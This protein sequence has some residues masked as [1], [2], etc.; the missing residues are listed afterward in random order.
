MSWYV[1]NFYSWQAHTRYG[2]QLD[3]LSGPWLLR[4]SQLCHAVL[5]PKDDPAYGHTAHPDFEH[6]SS[7]VNYT[8]NYIIHMWL[9]VK[10]VWEKEKLLMQ[11]IPLSPRAYDHTHLSLFQSFQDLVYLFK[12]DPKESINIRKTLFQGSVCTQ[13]LF[14]IHPQTWDLPSLLY[15]HASATS[16]SSENLKIIPLSQAQG[17]VC[18]SSFK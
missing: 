15:I 3:H 5:S 11:L 2:K 4:K 17:A 16:W 6:P 8:K 9:G 1:T 18:W 10:E 14:E 7:T 13:C 12:L